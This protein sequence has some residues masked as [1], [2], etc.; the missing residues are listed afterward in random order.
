MNQRP[1]R[2]LSLLVSLVA[3]LVLMAGCGESGDTVAVAPPVTP[4]L[5]PLQIEESD[6]LKVVGQTL[7]VQNPH[8]GLSVVDVSNPRAPRLVGRGG[9]AEQA[10]E[11]YLRDSTALVLLDHATSTCRNIAVPGAAW[12]PQA[13]LALVDVGTPT[14]PTLTGRYCMPGELVASRLMGKFLYLVTRRAEGGS[15]V[16]SVDVSWPSDVKLVQ[17][18]ELPSGATEIHLTEGMLYVAGR[19]QS[20]CSSGWCSY[21][22]GTRVTMVS[23]SAETGALRDVGSVVVTGEPQGRFHMDA[24]GGTFR[25]VTY[26]GANRRSLLHVIAT[27]QSNGPRA[28]SQLSIGV[29]ERLYATRFVGDRAYV[30]TFRQTDPLWVID[31]SSPTDPRILGELF[32]PGWSDFL[33]PQGE[34]RLLAVGRGDR[35]NGLGVSLFDVSDPMHPRVLAQQ[36]FGAYSDGVLSEANVDHRAV[37]LLDVGTQP[38]LVVPYATPTGQYSDSCRL[39]NRVQLIDVGRDTLTVRA[40]LEQ[41]GFVRRSLLVEGE[42]L[43]VSDYELLAVDVSDRDR[44]RVDG[45]LQLGDQRSLTASDAQQPVCYPRFEGDMATG[46]FLPFACSLSA[47][48]VSFAPPLSLLLLMALVALR[49]LRR[50][51]S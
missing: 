22:D 34:D 9:I 26:D 28:L 40:H 41:R 14:A 11:L 20:D 8:T 17:T 47:T 45:T 39:E 36:T 27:D 15:V 4:D 38:L 25:I 49:R 37:S 29:G 44:P 32:V 16:F 13:E 48:R 30:V 12:T 24:R 10:G 5:Q 31:L 21:E 3:A 7:Y 2:S 33:F 50:R 46:G 6:I 1:A 18:L 43:T 19:A 35:G 51:C 42:L 23:L